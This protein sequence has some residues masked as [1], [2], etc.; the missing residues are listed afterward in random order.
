MTGKEL[1]Q[2][3]LAAIAKSGLAERLK[4]LEE[5][6]PAER[7]EKGAPGESVKGERG[8]P[9][10][11]VKGEKGDAGDPGRDAVQ[12][13]PLPYIEADRSYARGTY[14]SHR[15]GLVR[16]TRTTDY[17]DTLRAGETVESKGWQIIL[18]GIAEQTVEQVD[19]RSFVVRL[20][21]T[22]GRATEKRCALPVMIYRGVWREAEY[23]RGDTATWG[24]SLWHCEE[25]T[26]EKPGT[27]KAWKLCVKKGADGKDAGK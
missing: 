21:D 4:K 13:D 23:Q 10:Q 25:P 11:S 5:R 26:S 22:A 18:S 20:T 12:I 27:G 7:G 1:G 2:I 8:E 6:P 14:A 19:E 15:G 24:G 16:A 3:I 9:G 17:L